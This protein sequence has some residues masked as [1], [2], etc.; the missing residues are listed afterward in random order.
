MI[1]VNV[2]TEVGVAAETAFAYL[3]DVTNNPEWQSGVE[4]TE[5]T[6]PRPGWLGATYDQTLEYKNMVISYRLAAVGPGRSMVVESGHGASVPNTVTRTVEI[7]S[8]DR[9]R[10]SVHLTGELGG[11]QKLAKPLVTRAIRRSIES[12]YRQLKR[13]LEGGDADAGI[14]DDDSSNGED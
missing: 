12:D 10:I 5:W 1:E 11:W 13:R 3:V 4:K 2:S 14:S 7:L 8:E 6:S 9:C